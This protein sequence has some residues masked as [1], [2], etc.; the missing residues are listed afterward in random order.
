MLVQAAARR[1]ELRVDSCAVHRPIQHFSHLDSGVPKHVDVSV[2]PHRSFTKISMGCCS[3]LP[4][5]CTSMTRAWNQFCNVRAS[6]CCITPGKSVLYM[7]MKDRLTSAAGGCSSPGS[8]FASCRGADCEAWP[9]VLVLAHLLCRTCPASSCCRS[10][11]SD[12][13]AGPP[14]C[15]ALLRAGSIYMFRRVAL[16]RAG[17]CDT[18]SGCG[19][20]YADSPTHCFHL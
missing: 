13:G 12:A 9:A 7:A 5:A 4:S 20:L 16:A 19:Y 15:V 8:C 10:R 1:F 18:T 6:E 3:R 2:L 11:A 14:G 17:A